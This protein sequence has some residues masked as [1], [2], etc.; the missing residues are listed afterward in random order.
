MQLKNNKERGVRFKDISNMRFGR[1]VAIESFK[2]WNCN[3]Y[4][5]KCK[6]DC[7]KEIECLGSN[8]LRGNTNSCGCLK[9][10]MVAD[11]RKKHGMSKT[12]I[13]KIWVGIRKRCTN[14]NCKAYSYYGGRGISV[15]ER[16]N[17][18]NNF[19]QDMK[20][21]YKDDLTLDRIDSNGNYEP[22]N[23]RWVSVKHQ[24]SNRRTNVFIEFNGE[25]KTLAQWQ[26]KTGVGY[27]T[28][29]NRIKAGWD[30]K[31][32]LFKSPMNKRMTLDSISEYL[33]F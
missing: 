20:D 23:C 13:F 7:G 27:K 16:W 3:K 12:R 29:S 18:F 21:D 2:K 24:N 6:C 1:L 31:D 15:C 8:L 4:F 5:W 9:N 17:D 10:D 22:S 30:I 28:I 32:A 11:L 26:K 19:Y 14:K 33:C 25:T